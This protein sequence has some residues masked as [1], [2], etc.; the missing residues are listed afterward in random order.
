MAEKGETLVSI[1]QATGVP[2]STVSE[3]LGNRSP[4]PIQAVLVAN[5]LGVSLHFLLFGEDDAQ[6]PLQRIMKEDFFKGTFEISIKRV[7][8]RED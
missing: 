8:I 3:W 6:E 1:S 7:K 4:N 5:H 2:K